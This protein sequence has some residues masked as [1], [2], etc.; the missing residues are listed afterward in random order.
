MK[1]IRKGLFYVLKKPSI[2]FDI[3]KQNI[4]LHFDLHHGNGNLEKAINLLDENDKDDF[5]ST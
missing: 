2:F 5:Y 3:N 1:L 4:K